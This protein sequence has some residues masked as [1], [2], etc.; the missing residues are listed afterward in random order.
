MIEPIDAKPTREQV[1]QRA[2]ELRESHNEL[3][4]ER[5]IIDLDCDRSVYAWVI[6]G[7]LRKR[8]AFK[9]MRN[10]RKLGYRYWLRIW[11]KPC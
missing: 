10:T 7:R 3:S 5:D 9:V 6:Y 4:I 2:E 1:E 11:V 8:I